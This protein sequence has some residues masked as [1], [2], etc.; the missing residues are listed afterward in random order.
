MDQYPRHLNGEEVCWWRLVFDGAYSPTNR[1]SPPPASTGSSRFDYTPDYG[2]GWLIPFAPKF[3]SSAAH[4]Y[5]KRESWRRPSPGKASR[6]SRT[7]GSVGEL[8][9][10]ST[11]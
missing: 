8:G 11:V 7:D 6:E 5:G 10:C 9:L 2:I 1:G 3:V 4:A